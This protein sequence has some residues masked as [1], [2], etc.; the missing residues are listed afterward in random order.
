[1]NGFEKY[2]LA[3]SI[4]SGEPLDDTDLDALLRSGL[5]KPDEM[6]MLLD[7]DPAG[8]PRTHWRYVGDRWDV[9]IDQGEPVLVPAITDGPRSGHG[10]VQECMG[11][12]LPILL[13][14][15]VYVVASGAALERDFV[16]C[17]GELWWFRGVPSNIH[18]AICCADGVVLGVHPHVALDAARDR[19]LCF[20]QTVHDMPSDLTW[21]RWETMVELGL[22]PSAAEQTRVWSAVVER[23]GD[24]NA[25]P[26]DA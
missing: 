26:H 4:L 23:T 3:N 13:A 6:E 21:E 20:L 19:V 16:N 18:I 12:A 10:I 5:I 8:D 2:L 9:K 14:D 1:M 11:A 24:D 7:T 25:E 15:V 22:A 17:G